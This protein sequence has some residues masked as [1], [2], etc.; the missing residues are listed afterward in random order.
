MA[1]Q[2]GVPKTFAAPER[3]FAIRQA[4]MNLIASARSEPPPALTHAVS[5]SLQRWRRADLE[6]WKR[7]VCQ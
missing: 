6:R 1:V 7:N 4:R 3:K 2:Q 5:G